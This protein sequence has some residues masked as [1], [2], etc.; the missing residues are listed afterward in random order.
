LWKKNARRD[1]NKNNNR[2][3]EKPLSNFSSGL[4]TYQTNRENCRKWHVIS[5]CSRN[6]ECSCAV[7]I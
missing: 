4:S 6:C 7:N 1:I 3:V 5:C 2:K